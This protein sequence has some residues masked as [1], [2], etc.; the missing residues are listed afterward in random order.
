MCDSEASCSKGYTF[1]IKSS[2]HLVGLLANGGFLSIQ[3]FGRVEALIKPV[4]NTMFV[5]LRL[6]ARFTKS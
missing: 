4:Q 1:L 3:Q 2:R 5:L 6:K